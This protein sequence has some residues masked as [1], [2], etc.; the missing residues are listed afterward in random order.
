MKRTVAVLLGLL[1]ASAATGTV[2]V[3]QEDEGGWPREIEAG[4]HRIPIYQP[5]LE[6]FTGDTLKGRRLSLVRPDGAGGRRIAGFVTVAAT[7]R[8]SRGCAKTRLWTENPLL[9]HD[10]SSS[11]RS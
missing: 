10:R 11:I 1:L 9:L 2:S 6:T 3:A 8:P 5:Q 4:G 7:R